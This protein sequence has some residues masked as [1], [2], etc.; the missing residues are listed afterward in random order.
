M[1]KKSLMERIEAVDSPEAAIDVF[2]DL[3][4]SYKAAVLSL[5]Q[6]AT[7]S[8]HYLEE[9]NRLWSDIRD[10]E[11]TVERLN[12]ELRELSVKMP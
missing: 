8:A 3:V 5:D 7:Q 12:K 10:Y 6:A 9:I 11:K 4:S 2:D 1:P